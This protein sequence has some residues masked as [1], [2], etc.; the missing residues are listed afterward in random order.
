MNSNPV[1][2]DFSKAFP[3]TNNG[4]VTLDFSQAQPL[5]GSTSSITDNPNGEGVYQM[6]DA[7]GNTVGIPYGNV[8]QAAQQG[9]SWANNQEQQRFQKDNAAD[10]ATP[11]PN[12]MA[13][14][15]GDNL[16]TRTA[17]LAGGLLEGAGEG[18]LQTITG[19]DRWAREHLPAVLTN[20]NMGF[21][22]P[23][24]L[25]KVDQISGKTDT[26]QTV[27]EKAGQLAEG[28]GEYFL[29]DAALKA[30]PISERLAAV[31]KLTKL[32]ESNP[33]IAA[34]IGGAIRN[35]TVSGTET[36]L[37]TGDAGDSLGAAALG[38]AIGGVGE[39]AIA[40]AADAASVDE[41]SL[42]KQVLKGKDVNQPLAQDA[43]RTAVK[44][45]AQDAGTANDAMLSAIDNEPI[46]K[47]GT[48]ILDDHLKALQQNAK[49]AYKQ[50]DDT[51]GFD[52]KAEKLQLKN[53]QYKLSQ[54]GNT[55]ADIRQ[56][57]NLIEAI[58]DSESRIAEAEA[59]LKAAG[60]DP[61]APDAIH[62]QLQAGMDF[63]GVLRR[64][65]NPDGSINVDQLTKQSNA[66]RF[67]KKGDR[68]TQFFGSKDAA[69]AYMN[70]LQQAQ[71]VGVHA[72]K[73]QGVAK[74][75]VKYGGGALG[76]GY[77]GHGLHLIGE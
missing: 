59:N 60:I 51:V 36:F 7:K 2:L 18:A 14:Q 47:N 21:G 54:L 38:G 6:R 5:S 34:A 70:Q 16:V 24:D 62:R 73:A 8:Q 61:K 33:A 13:Y 57:G 52:L 50:V 49:A 29:G 30:L 65:T 63:K 75:I 64:S 77:L 4:S 28:I 22:P 68:L 17:K 66:L 56:R 37:K 45:S 74:M 53:D 40:P 43:L 12:P 67:S 55:D 23:A 10:P 27:S 58:N 31:S 32:A 15:P 25:D 3:I 44:T 19:T 1:Q 48:T 71:K 69:D 72:M 46:Q 11:K 39:A 42:L 41:P 76:L 26:N 20:S 35:A 9:Y